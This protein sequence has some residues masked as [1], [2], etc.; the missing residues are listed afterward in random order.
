MVSPIQPKELILPS[1]Q[2]NM[3]SSKEQTLLISESTISIDGHL[4]SFSSQ[5]EK[6]EENFDLAQSLDYYLV[7]PE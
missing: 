3:I 2:K 1:S 7:F 4:I 6:T 5:G